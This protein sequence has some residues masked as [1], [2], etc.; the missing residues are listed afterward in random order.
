MSF[1]TDC[2]LSPE[3]NISIGTLAIIV[4]VV[5]SSCTVACLAA[6]TCWMAAN[7]KS[8]RYALLV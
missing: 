6:I 8:A 7:K 4:V 1:N 3:V 2:P 5:V